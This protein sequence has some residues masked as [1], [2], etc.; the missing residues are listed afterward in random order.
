MV[1]HWAPPP[2]CLPHISGK[3]PGVVVVGS[4]MRW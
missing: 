4:D 3:L 1:G 2:R